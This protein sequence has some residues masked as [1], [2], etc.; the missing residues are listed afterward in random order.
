MT[1]A[2]DSGGTMV[3]MHMGKANTVVRRRRGV[4]ADMLGRVMVLLRDLFSALRVVLLRG[5]LAL[6]T[7]SEVVTGVLVVVMVGT[8]T[9]SP[10]HLL[11]LISR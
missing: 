6:T 8:V 1:R 5:H 7:G 10:L 3:T 11:L 2:G 4:A 9:G